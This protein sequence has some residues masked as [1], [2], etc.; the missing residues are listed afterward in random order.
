VDSAGI[1]L[2]NRGIGTLIYQVTDVPVVKGS[3]F[4]T[5]AQ[6]SPKDLWIF[7]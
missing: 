1:Q 5:N 2:G 3:V 7:C 4:C 6:S